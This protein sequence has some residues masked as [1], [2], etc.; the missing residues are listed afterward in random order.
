MEYGV[1]IHWISLIKKQ[2]NRVKKKRDVQ[3][4]ADFDQIH[5]KVREIKGDQ[6]FGE[7]SNATDRSSSRHVF[8]NFTN[9]ILRIFLTNIAQYLF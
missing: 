5:E 4:G 1:L 6:K 7:N 2:E 3:K 9:T 8:T